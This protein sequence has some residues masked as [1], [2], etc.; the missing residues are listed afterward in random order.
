MNRNVKYDHQKDLQSEKQKNIEMID[1]LKND[2][3]KV[4]GHLQV[5][6]QNN[7]VLKNMVDQLETKN[8]EIESQLRVSKL[9][10]ADRTNEI[11]SMKTTIEELRKKNKELEKMAEKLEERNESCQSSDADLIISKQET[12]E[13]NEELEGK[14]QQFLMRIRLIK[15]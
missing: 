13:C 12:K 8:E 5:T 2:K 7:E 1:Q 15:L 11:D 6:R 4:K 14:A 10:I 9:E 3:V